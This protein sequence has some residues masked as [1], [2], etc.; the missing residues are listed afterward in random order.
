MCKLKSAIV[1]K[2]KIFMPF[3]YD[4][5]EQMIAE[6]KLSDDTRSPEFVRVEMVPADGDVFNHNLD[7]WGLI[8]DQDFRPEWF[9]EKFAEEEMKTEIKKFFV[10]RFIV[11]D[12]TWQRRD[13]QRLFIKNSSVVAWGNSSVVAR[14]NSSVEAREN[15]S[16]VA[17]GNSSVVARGNSSVEARGNSS[18]EA[19]ENSS[20]EAWENSSVVAWGNSSVVARGNSS[21]VARENSSVEA[22]GNSSVEA[23]GNSSV[24]A[25]EN[26]SVV[27]WGN[28]SVVARGNSSVVARENSSVE[29]RG[30]SS[31]EAWGN[32][33]ILLPYD[34]PVK[35]KGVYDNASV[36]DIAHSKIFIANPKLKLI[37]FKL[38]K[39]AKPNVKK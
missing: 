34:Y 6:L 8:V 24:V 23:R 13:H 32:S 28:S 12:R 30:N 38:P 35:I 11:N 18:V 9:N 7:N 5:H 29:A 21:V 25:R 4:S 14:E 3:D 37:K 10:E 26:S 27:A 39:E 15:S 31:V 22:W 33:Q 17:W 1:L 16:V 20:V 36:K 19:R 2:D